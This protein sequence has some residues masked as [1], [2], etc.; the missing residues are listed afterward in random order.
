MEIIISARHFDLTQAIKDH[1]TAS[2]EAA[3][4]DLKLK[5]SK[6]TMVIDIQ[7]NMTKAS[8]LVAIKGVPVEAASEAYDNMYKAVDESVERAAVQARK[9]LDKK[10]DHKKDPTIKG[11]D[12]PETQE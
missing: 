12:L 3:F 8:V 11:A 6:V 9:Y 1:A 7:K 10:Q 2:I 5:I 4:A